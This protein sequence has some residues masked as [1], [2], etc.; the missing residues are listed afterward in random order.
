VYLMVSQKFGCGAVNFH[1]ASVCFERFE[2][3]GCV[4]SD[5]FLFEW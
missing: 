3:I 5:T 2:W 1:M 4:H